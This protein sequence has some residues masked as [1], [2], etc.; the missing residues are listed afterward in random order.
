MVAGEGAASPSM[1]VGARKEDESSWG[2]KEK[3]LECIIY[4]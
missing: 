3:C 1:T 4:D 2:E